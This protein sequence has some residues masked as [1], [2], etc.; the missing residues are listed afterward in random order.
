MD[1][2]LKNPTVKSFLKGFARTDYNETIKQLVLIGI[3]TVLA[4]FKGASTK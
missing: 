2:I 1:S 4:K 3:E